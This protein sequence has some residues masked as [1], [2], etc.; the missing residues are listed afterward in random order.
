[1]RVIVIGAGIGGLA[2]AQALRSVPLRVL[3]AHGLDDAIRWGSEYV[4]HE[5]HPDGT[6]TAT[7]ADGSAD[8]GDL[9]V[10]AD[11]ATSR[12]ATALAGRPTSSPVGIGGIAGRSPL[13]PEIRAL[14]PDLLRIGS[15]LAVGP[16]GTSIF[17][18]LQDTV[19]G[20]ALDPALCVDVPAFPEPPVV[21]WGVNVALDRLPNARKM[22]AE[23]AVRAAGDLLRGWSP[24]VRKIVSG[25]DPSSV[26]TFQYHTCDPDAHLTP[27]PSGTVTALGDAVHAMP[28]TGG[29]AAATAIRDA[30]LLATHLADAA[31]G[32]TTIPLAVHEYER[33]PAAYAADAVRVSLKPIVWQRRLA[34]P[35]LG[36]LVRVAT[37]IASPLT[38]AFR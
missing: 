11:G 4:G 8:H 25:A 38:A 31:K 26:G 18:T 7:F 16:G 28:P 21:Y 1:M 17:I 35:A 30:D 9:L 12:V 5:T 3:L 23:A 2:L 14:L 10:G 24:V 22:G 20:P 37:A 13:T 32:L 15:I 29:R 19:P 6:V 27:W 34:N 33:G 36:Q